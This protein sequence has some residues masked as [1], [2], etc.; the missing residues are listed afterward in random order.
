M[1]GSQYYR[2]FFFF[3]FPVYTCFN[4]LGFSG[5]DFPLVHMMIFLWMFQDFIFPCLPYA[6]FVLYSRPLILSFTHSLLNTLIAH[7]RIWLVGSAPQTD[8]KQTN[9]YIR[10]YIA[11]TTFSFLNCCERK[12]Q[13]VPSWDLQLTYIYFILHHTSHCFIDMPRFFPILPSFLNFFVFESVYGHPFYFPRLSSNAPSSRKAFPV[14]LGYNLP[15]SKV[16][17]QIR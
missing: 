14:T 10:G 6:C 11:S 2:L 17:P 3:F 13:W 16:N 1:N 5:R 4:S 7:S 12:S 15:C 8:A 9:H